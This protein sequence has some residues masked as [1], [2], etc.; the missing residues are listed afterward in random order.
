M[1]RL[2]R[3]RVHSKALQHNIMVAKKHAPDANV[4]VAVK[5]NAYGHGGLQ[6]A[7]ICQN[8]CDGFM[9]ASLYEGIVLRQQG[10]ILPI[11]SIQGFS[12]ADDIKEAIQYNIRCVIHSLSQLVLLESH[13]ESASNLKITLK[14]DTGMHRL[15]LAPESVASSYQRIKSLV[16]VNSSVWL[17]SHL[18]CAD[19]LENDYTRQ[20]QDCFNQLTESIDASKSLANSAAIL[21]WE[22]MQ[23]DWVRPGIMIYGSSPFA[24]HSAIE[25]GLQA[26]MTFEAP[27]ITIQQL[28]KGDAIGYGQTWQCPEDRLVGIVACGYGDGYPRHA[29][30]GTVVSVNQQRTQIIGRVS[31]DVIVID[32]HNIQAEIGDW[33]ECWGENIAVDDVALSAG[34]ISY[35]LLCSAG[36]AV[37]VYE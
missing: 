12:S 9:V 35:E 22:N 19:E 2:A 27:L 4:M 29:P 20:Q 7:K 14:I 32:L 28:N 15:G 13:P 21:G 11:L 1:T 33:V 10:I 34:T 25:L 18:A 30:S 3:L 17:M 36:R 31:M 23:Y 6:T 16:S 8:Y 37:A 5:A 26:A 24:T